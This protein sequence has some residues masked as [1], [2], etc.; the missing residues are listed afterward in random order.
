MADSWEDLE[1]VDVKVPLSNQDSNWSWNVEV[2]EA[3]EVLKPPK[4]EAVKQVPAASKAESKPKKTQKSQL[5]TKIQEREAKEASKKTSLSVQDEPQ[6][7]LL[8]MS[9]AERKKLLEAL[10]RESDLQHAKELFGN[11]DVKEEQE[12]DSF[13]PVTEEDLEKFCSILSR[14]LETVMSGKK[15]SLVV[16]FYKK[17]LRNVTSDLKVED[18]KELVAHLNVLSNEKLKANQ[19]KK[20]GKQKKKAVVK[21][22]AED[23][24]LGL[25]N[26]YEDF[27]TMS[28][29][30]IVLSVRLV[31]SF[32]YRT[33]KYIVLKDV[34]LHTTGK[35]LK[36]RIKTT[37]RNSPS[38]RSYESCPFDTLKIYTPSGSSH[39]EQSLV[40][41]FDHEDWIIGDNDTL[42][43]KRVANEAE[44]SFFNCEQYEK[45]K[46]HPDVKW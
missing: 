25:D 46:Q 6:D 17:L 10:E 3:K 44:I 22:D 5:A 43:S 14:K 41:N 40:I 11:G 37:L 29:T 24:V 42:E 19:D 34:S 39:K 1:E 38:L 30:K 12:L 32:E 33:I 18:I 35:E 4:K 15:P 26:D 7:E 21:V 45:F 8:G 28:K 23:D 2:E 9:E 13:E 27:I 36:E 16:G 20:K 31:K